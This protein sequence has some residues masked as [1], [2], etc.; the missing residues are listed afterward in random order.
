MTRRSF[1]TSLAAVAI[2]PLAVLKGGPMV[3]L[4]QFLVEAPGPPPRHFL[5]VSNI[6]LMAKLVRS[7]IRC[8]R[9]NPDTGTYT[10]IKWGRPNLPIWLQRTERR[11]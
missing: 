10:L 11:F 4:P 6:S 8:W 2:T 5:K 3:A 9:L 1:F 7:G